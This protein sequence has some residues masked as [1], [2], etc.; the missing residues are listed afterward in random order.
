[1]KNITI[2]EV[3]HVTTIAGVAK[4]RT[5]D[6]VLHELQVGDILQPGMEI[7]LS[8]ASNFAFE[9]GLPEAIQTP[10][11]SADQQPSMPAMGA[12]NGEQTAVANGD[13]TTAQINALQQS[14]LSGQDPTQAFEAAA[15]GIAADAGGTGPGSGNGGFI[16]VA[17]VGDATIAESGYDTAAPTTD[18][19]LQINVPAAPTANSPTIVT[20]DTNTIAED[21]VATGNVLVNDSDTDSVLSVAGFAVNGSNFSAG[22][23]ANLNGIGTLVINPDGSYVFTPDPNWNGVVPQVTYTTNTGA[24]STLDINV[25][26][27]N[28]T[29]NAVND[30]P[31]ANPDALTTKED[32]PLTILPAALLANDTDVDG[33]TL[34]ITSVQGA[35]NGT[36]A[37]V[38][39]NVVFTPAENY[40]GSASFTYTI[41]DGHGGT[42][43]AIVTINV[44]PVNDSP[45]DD[46]EA[47]VL[48][49]DSG[50]YVAVGNALTNA[51]DVDGD[52]LTI[53]AGTGETKGSYGTLILGSNG[54]YTYTLDNASAAV[55]SLKTG[56][57]VQDTFTYTVS[58]G[59]GG[60]TDSTITI[61]ILGA[62]D[63]AHVTVSAEGADAT[64]YEHGLLT[65]PDTSETDG[66]SFQV[67][68]SDGIKEVVIGGTTFSLAQLQDA[69]YLAAH[70]V[71]TGEGTLT[72]T[73]YSSSDDQSATI[74]YSYTLDAAQQHGLPG[75]ATD[76]TLTDSVGVTVNGVGG[77]SDSANLSISIIDDVPVATG[78]GSQTVTEDGNGTTTLQSVTGGVL[79]N[80]SYGADGA[81]ADAGTAFS[82]DANTAA[83]AA[84]ATYG[85]LTLGSDG[86]Y[87]FTLDNSSAAVQGL[88]SSSV[89]EQTLTYT[90]TDHDGDTSPAS[91]TIRIVGADD[92]AHVTVSAEGADA[93]VY[94]HGLLTVPDTSETDGG[95]FQVFASDGIKEVVIGGTTFSLAQLQD[96]GYLAAHTVNTGEGTLTLTGYSSSDDQSA[97][98]TYSYTLDAAQQHGLPGSATDSTLT[99]SVG[100]TVNGVGGSSDS[101]NLS[102]SIIDDVPTFTHI[103]NAI[104]ANAT[105]TLIGAHDITLGADGE[106]VIN[107][108][109]LTTI[110]GL[111]YSTPVHNSDGSTV[112]TAGTGT[113]TTGFFSLTI[114]PDGEYLFNL[115]DPRPDVTKIADF[116][117]ITGG[118]GVTSLTLNSGLDAITFTGDGGDKIKPTSAGFG[119]ND[120]NLDPGDDF[121]VSF[122]G[123]LVDSV[124]FT[125]NQE[126]S[127]PFKLQWQTDTDATWHEVTYAADGNLT[128]DPSTD[129][130]TIYFEVLDGKAKVD[131]FSYSQNLLPENQVLQFSVSA[132]DG[133][134]DLT[135][136]QILN[137]EL[138][139]G[140]IGA[141]ILGTN[142]DDAIMGTASGE[143][144]TGGLGNDILTGGD[145]AD[146]FV[147][148]A[149]D[150]AGDHYKDTITD[151]SINTV[152]GDKLDLSA[153]LNGDTDTNLDN[154]LQFSK[155]SAGDAVISVHK[156]GDLTSTPD[157]TIVVEGHGATDADLTA[158]QT[159]LLSQDGLIH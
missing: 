144:I 82:W 53:S 11:Q 159:Y 121:H 81:N 66:G 115:L 129:F 47:H 38:D 30:D 74:T 123:N 25:T 34:I 155:D 77:S 94:E 26:A 148:T 69:G 143:H 37:L 113:S 138:L 137:V 63:S 83:K 97:T 98:I 10:E 87:T 36:V 33:D 133:D 19:L 61:N 99:D 100:V 60:T 103:D 122:A 130:S 90:I 71:N 12:V 4:F 108:S 58:D 78:D 5:P 16:S 56:D 142:G 45:V 22:N 7:I 65:V 117:S 43:T 158:L 41:S 42:D 93:T 141:D 85:T 72:L 96:A 32:T 92:S 27:V 145:G 88:T 86:T 54:E 28:D 110:S 48:T 149:A 91:V 119:V 101:A 8:D 157:M 152:N 116:G 107:I 109:A 105:G 139:G 131:Q 14:I 9:K 40:H 150:V 140:A 106:G 2:T 153:V 21:T 102:I 31:I 39:G 6:G 120:G 46:N 124:T 154:Y 55:Q 118:A 156:D 1:M 70:T 111:N 23:T 136:P 146:T 112:I 62:D 89:I 79:G 49:E 57:T 17:R 135:S 80:D 44:S 3:S 24:S 67:F 73:G 104:A 114:N 151:F 127:T 29:P 147:W 75:S 15:A 128:I 134:H 13:Q 52:P 125:I 51:S 95:S 18:Q 59:N 84:L 20:P 132:T 35:T 64:V 76:S 50:I 68:A 126:S